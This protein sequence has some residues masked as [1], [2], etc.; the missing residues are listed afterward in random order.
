MAKVGAAA[1]QTYVAI[2]SLRS[3]FKTW[4]DDSASATDKVLA[5]LMGI[6]MAVPNLI[7]AVKN[8]SG[9]FAGLSMGGAA[10]IIAIT[11][12]VVALGIHL[13]EAVEAARNLPYTQAA[14]AAEA[15]N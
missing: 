1:M 5:G 10:A 2:N 13:Y 6:G 12:A 7:G 15:A 14:N 3:M 11:A 4:G 8:L 9:A